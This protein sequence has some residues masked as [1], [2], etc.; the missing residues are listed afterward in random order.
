M[1]YLGFKEALSRFTV[2]S[3]SD[4]RK[5]APQFQPRR[6]CEWQ[7]KG[8]I[9]KII[10]GHYRFNDQ[11]LHEET[12]FEIANRIYNPSYISLEMAL[13]YYR[14]IPEGVYGIT[15]ISTRRTY[16]FKTPIAEFIFHTLH[17][18]YFFG[19][20]IREYNGKHFK[21]ASLEKAVLDF[22]YFN[23][24]LK[25]PSDFEALRLNKAV[26][27]SDL[28]EKKLKAFLKRFGQP[29]LTRRADAFLRAIKS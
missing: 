11:E 14:L 5:V 29:Q 13:S 7:A 17:R 6:L 10:K 18:K 27:A 8:Y 28:N 16:R 23:E 15:S 9:Q 25:T 20:V 4:I 3:L 12:L 21:I 22:L 19:Y 2:F 26:L 1:H 24:T